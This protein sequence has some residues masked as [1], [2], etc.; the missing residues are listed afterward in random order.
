MFRLCLV[1]LCLPFLAG[2]ALPEFDITPPE[3]YTEVYNQTMGE[4]HIVAWRNDETGVVLQMVDIRKVDPEFQKDGPDYFN[5]LCQGFI[6]G[7]GGAFLGHG[8]VL[9]HETPWLWQ[10]MTKSSPNGD[11]GACLMYYFRGR[12]EGGVMLGFLG[13]GAEEADLRDYS[14][15]ALPLIVGVA[16]STAVVPGQPSTPQLNR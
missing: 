10:S 3:G 2:L 16:D 5:G 7:T 9:V 12:A 1:A 6:D 11:L 8:D 13:L 4:Q 14:L 15:E